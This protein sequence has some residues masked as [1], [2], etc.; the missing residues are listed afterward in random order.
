MVNELNGLLESYLRDM[1]GDV[2]S[3]VVSDANGLPITYKT[4]INLSVES[5][6][7][8]CSLTINRMQRISGEI[9]LGDVE[10]M[11]ISYSGYVLYIERIYGD[12]LLIVVAS[13]DANMGLVMYVTGKYAERISN[14]IKSTKGS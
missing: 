11:I 5:L 4:T 14:L 3:V 7:A 12:L 6:S 13:K 9:K 10:Y 8:L 2:V 1:E